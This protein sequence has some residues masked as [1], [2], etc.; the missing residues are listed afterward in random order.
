MMIAINRITLLK[1]VENNNQRPGQTPAV[2][3]WTININE[4]IAERDPKKSLINPDSKYKGAN[5]KDLLSRK[6]I[7]HNHNQDN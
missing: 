4:Q 7:Q 2:F 5:Q 1:A 3:V 6:E